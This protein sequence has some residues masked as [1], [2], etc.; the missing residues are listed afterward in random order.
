M[1]QSAARSIITCDLEGRIQTFNEGAENLFGYSPEEVI[2]QKRVSLFSPGLIVLGH[3]GNWLKIARTKGEFSTR[4]AFLRKDGTPFA[5]E[6]RI[7]PTYRRIEGHKRLIGYCG[8]TRAL[9][10]VDVSEVMPQISWA[11]R[12]MAWLIVTRAPFLTATLMPVLIAS[13]WA[14]SQTGTAGFPW[15]LFASALAGAFALHIA[16][17]TFNDYFDWRS[18]T[19]P[20][21]ADYFVPYTGGSRSIE[22]GLITERALLR[23]AVAS[24]VAAVLFAIPVLLARSPGI[25]A[26]GVAGAAL[27]YFYTAPPVR[28]SARH[29]LG[30][31]SIMLAFGPLLTA[32]TV[33]SLTGS[34]GPGA[35]LIGV[36]IGV[37]A[38]AILWVNQF[39]DTEAD[40]GTGKNHLLVTVGKRAGRW[41]Y[42]LFLGI[43]YDSVL[44][45]VLAG[46]FAPGT[47]LVFVGLPLAAYATVTVFRHYLDRELIRASKATIQLHFISGLLL[48]AGL[49]WSTVA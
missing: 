3:V 18:G 49:L 5:A 31:L 44:F 42:V 2:G 32:G 21:N 29:G 43:A 13:A 12:L 10:G 38:V 14:L 25:L 45:L 11:T 41:F 37:L 7:T 39:P 46:V 33:Y 36:P 24:L 27:A 30:E 40:A 16:A 28:L 19:D 4:T 48:S 23:L 17:N 9:P 47:L 8:L 15:G 1:R 20:A 34:A 6:I 35:Y 22:L 26:F